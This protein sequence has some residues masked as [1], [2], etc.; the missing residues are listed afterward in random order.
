MSPC[1]HVKRPFHVIVKHTMATETSGDYQ[2]GNTGP[3]CGPSTHRTEM[4]SE[5]FTCFR[6]LRRNRMWNRMLKTYLRIQL[7]NRLRVFWP[8]IW[9]L[10]GL[11]VRL[12]DEVVPVDSS[13]RAAQNCIACQSDNFFHLLVICGS[14]CNEACRGVDAW[15]IIW[16]VYFCFVF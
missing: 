11:L 4:F 13:D 2:P 7:I 6:R 5:I 16:R 3:L 12:T 15:W 1:M 10:A 14:H 9:M 8:C